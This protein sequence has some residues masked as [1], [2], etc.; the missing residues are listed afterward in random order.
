MTVYV[1]HQAIDKSFAVYVG[2][3][4]DAEGDYDRLYS[5]GIIDGHKVTEDEARGEALAYG[6]K[7]AKKYGGLVEL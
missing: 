6:Q 4:L 2:G 3:D 7:I 5:Y 1:E